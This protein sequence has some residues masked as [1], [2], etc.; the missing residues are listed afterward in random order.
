MRLRIETFGNAR[1]NS[2]VAPWIQAVRIQFVPP[3]FIPVMLA[4]AIA[5]ARYGVFDPVAFLLVVI[6]VTV[7][8]FG[9]NMLDDV[10]DYLLPED[11]RDYDDEVTDRMMARNIDG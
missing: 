2:L 9:L 11:W 5:W 8:H 3:S 10:L 7:H 6:G 4:A 1:E